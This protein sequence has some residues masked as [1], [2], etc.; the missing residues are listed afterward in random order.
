MPGVL[1]ILTG[2]LLAWVVGAN[3]AANSMGTA[4]GSGVRTP[5]QGA[6][7]AGVCGLA[8]AI[9]MGGRVVKTLGEGILP[10]PDLPVVFAQLI[11]VSALAAAGLTV[12]TC[13][14]LRLPVSTSHAVTGGLVGGGF[15][16]GVQS[17]IAWRE[18][19]RIF[20][21]WFFT[22]VAACLLAVVIYRLGRYLFAQKNFF[23]LSDRAGKILVT[24][25]GC[26]MA[27]SWGA[28][29]VA[30]ATGVL[31]G[32]LAFPPLLITL[33]GGMVMVCGV[34]IWGERIMLTVGKKITRLSP[35]TALAAEFTAA[36]VVHFFTLAGLPVS[37]TH[38]IVG[39]VGGI[40]LSKGKKSVTLPLLGGIVL[41]WMV[42]PFFAGSL[43]F[44]LYR[45]LQLAVVM[46]G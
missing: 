18:T 40:G 25:T 5:R 7:L 23:Y 21:A 44:F 39:A 26:Y 3:D 36:V 12:L 35:A 15:S 1:L 41:T 38:A 32:I 29:D 27:F 19:A 24:I 42:T 13:T 20:C 46:T 30:N 4:V 34:L 2:L 14:G 33:A 10:L 37:T 45:L 6:V 22:P 43:A 8:G 11:A 16:A 28:N 31:S 9:L 17:L